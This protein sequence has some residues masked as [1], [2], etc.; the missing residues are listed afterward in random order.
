MAIAKDEH[1]MGALLHIDNR[2]GQEQAAVLCS[3]WEVS[4]VA[5]CV[6]SPRKVYNAALRGMKTLCLDTIIPSLAF[7]V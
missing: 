5:G 7:R 6:L 4:R 2:E 1:T 3:A